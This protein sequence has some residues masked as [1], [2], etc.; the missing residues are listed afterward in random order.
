MIMRGFLFLAVMA[1]GLVFGGALAAMEAPQVRD[2]ETLSYGAEKL[3]A[4]D[5]WRAR[6]ASAPLTVFVHGGA[7]RAGDKNVSSKTWQVPYFLSKGHAF[8]SVNYRLVPDVGVAQQAED[9]A[10]SLKFLVDRAD[11]L[12]FDRKRIVLMGHSAGAHLAALVTTDERYLQQV[13]L[14]VSDIAGVILLDGAGYD[15]PRQMAVAGPLMQRTYRMAFGQDPA[16]QRALSPISHAASPNAR[17][18]LVLHV[19]RPDSAEQSR[20]LADALQQGGTRAEVHG[21]P[22]EGRSGHRE[23]NVEL[24]DPSYSGTAIV[25]RWL[26]G[27]L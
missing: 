8:A 24:G 7:W 21:L 22:G 3:Q 19:Q 13:G 16:Q 14:Q 11:A 12:G 23:I 4:L 27:V 10:R 18:F 9:V 2:P 25:D 5:F 15:V 6:T 1:V 26:G 17:A 20:A